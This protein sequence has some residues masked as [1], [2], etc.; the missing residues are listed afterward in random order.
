VRFE[1][2]WADCSG[3]AWL[4]LI[5]HDCALGRGLGVGSE[6]CQTYPI[7]SKWR[8]KRFVWLGVAEISSSLARNWRNWVRFAELQRRV[9]RLRLLQRGRFLDFVLHRVAFH[10]SERRAKARL[11]IGFASHNGVVGRMRRALGACYRRLFFRFCVT[12][13]YILLRASRLAWRES[14]PAAVEIVKE[15]GWPRQNAL[16]RVREGCFGGSDIY[17]RCKSSTHLRGDRGSR[18]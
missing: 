16:R 13:R 5:V 1:A 14:L 2:R 10:T 17:A 18:A 4:G 3:C 15:H 8:G 9:G 6:M 12:S 11:G 7:A